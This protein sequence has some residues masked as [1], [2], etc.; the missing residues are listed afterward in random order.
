MRPKLPPRLWL[1]NARKDASGK[2]THCAKWFIRYGSLCKPTTYC[3]HEREEAEIFFAKLLASPGL[4]E[5]KLKS[6]RKPG[7][8]KV[9]DTFGEIYFISKEG[10]DEYPV[11]IGFSFNDI[12]MRLKNIQ[13]G[14][15]NKLCII[16]TFSAHHAVE[17]EL[18]SILASDRMVGEWFR[19]SS[20]V[21]GAMN[22]AKCGILK[23][24][25]EFRSTSNV[26]DSDAA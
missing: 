7:I 23:S 24:W 11:K 17:V 18:H 19:R 9:S 21:N 4:L 14:N 5:N 25:M 16:T 6:R 3:E 26:L 20:N 22:A 15:P 8:S 10:C 12:Y 1:R 13:V 2:I